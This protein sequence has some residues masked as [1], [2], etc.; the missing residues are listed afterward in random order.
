MPL[1]FAAYPLIFDLCIARNE[2][3][4]FLLEHSTMRKDICYYANTEPAETLVFRLQAREAPADGVIR[5]LA[6]LSRK[7]DGVRIA[8]VDSIKRRV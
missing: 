1:Y 6:T 8:E 4:G 5:H 3:K 2:A 7:S